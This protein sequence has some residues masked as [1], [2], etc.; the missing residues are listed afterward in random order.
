MSC[1]TRAQ[2]E[3]GLLLGLWVRMRVRGLRPYLGGS[4]LL[5]GGGFMLWAAVFRSDVRIVRVILLGCGLALAALGVFEI[6]T[7][8]RRRYPIHDERD[9]REAG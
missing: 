2:R 3:R 9:H 4:Y 5:V 8:M 6:V 1:P 7:A